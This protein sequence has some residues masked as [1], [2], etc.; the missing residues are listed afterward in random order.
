MCR[1]ELPP[2]PEKLYEEARRRCVEVKRSVDRGEVSWGRLTK[3]Q[4]REMNEVIRLLRT[5]ADQ[6]HADAQ[7]SLG[8]MYG[9]GEGVKQDFAEAARWFRKAADQGLAGAQ[10]NLG[11]KYAHGQGVK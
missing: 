5:T 8:F 2:G 1:V 11:V 9:K 3:A 6:G 4:Q 10:Y 7:N